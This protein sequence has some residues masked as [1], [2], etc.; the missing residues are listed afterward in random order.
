[1]CAL[2]KSGRQTT[3]VSFFLLV[4]ANLVQSLWEDSNGRATSRRDLDPSPPE[5]EL[6]GASHQASHGEMTQSQ[7]D[8]GHAT[9]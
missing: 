3:L 5:E 7:P 6:S 2:C 4:S 9:H 1:M 8:L